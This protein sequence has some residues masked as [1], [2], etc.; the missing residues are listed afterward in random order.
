[1]IHRGQ[2]SG[3]HL[4]IVTV[5]T[6][7]LV[8]SLFI[9][10]HLHSMLNAQLG[11]FK[12]PPPFHEYALLVY[13][14]IPVW[15]S[16]GFLFGLHDMHGGTWSGA[17]IFWALIKQHGIGLIL[18]SL[19]LFIGQI[20]I[21]RSLV[22]LF[23]LSS[24]LSMLL[25]RL[26]ILARLRYLYRT[27]QGQ[28]RMLLVGEPS[29][30]MDRFLR[31]ASGETCP[32][33]IIG[34]LSTVQP[35]EVDGTT[36]RD[37]E[38]LL[39]PFLGTPEDLEG[40]L[41]EHAVDQVLFFPP[42]NQP[43]AGQRCLEVCSTL[44][45]AAYFSVDWMHLPDVSVRFLSL[46]AQPFVYY[47]KQIGRGRGMAFKA[48]L[49]FVSALFGM[50]LLAPLFF[51]VALACLLFQGRPVIYRQE[52]VGLNGRRFEI[53]KFR[54]MKANADALEPSEDSPVTMKE[55]SD[56]RITPLGRFLRKSSLDEIP[57]LFNVLNGSMS[58]VG[59]RPLPI[60]EQQRIE[61]TPRRRLSMKP[62]ITG[63]WQVSGRSDLDFEQWMEL[64]LYYVD[65]WSFGLDLRVMLRTFWVVLR[66]KGA[67]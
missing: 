5:D 17:A 1:M 27:G 38:L 23:A 25:F 32:T 47:D 31:R 30:S 21:N 15:L 66:G 51:L 11:I 34:C 52:R 9:T 13:L 22:G 2:Q 44:G 35:E 36:E 16:L 56:P 62:G 60:E 37:G 18:L 10:H 49:D 26:L 50:L 40:I 46:D 54:T 64:D 28:M 67:R 12:I 65:N 20:V 19:I 58:L 55:A 8:A 59:P 3:Q 24:L 61:G 57:Q 48:G 63:L 6:L 42:F 43:Q 14:V 41:K 4:V 53:L 29:A 45:I 7:L 39:P 33:K